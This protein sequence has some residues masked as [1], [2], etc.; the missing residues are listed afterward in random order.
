MIFLKGKVDKVVALRFVLNKGFWRYEIY[1]IEGRVD[2][3]LGKRLK[4]DGDGWIVFFVVASW[5]FGLI[6]LRNF[7][8]GITSLS[9]FEGDKVA[10]IVVL[11]A[12]GRKVI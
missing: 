7:F 8:F 5:D 11:K 4:V 12:V 9:L 6:V 2:S 3:I 1:D 10:F